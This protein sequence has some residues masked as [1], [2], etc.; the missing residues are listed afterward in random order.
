MKYAKSVT[1]TGS[2]SDSAVS[3]IYKVRSPVKLY[4]LHIL[5]YTTILSKSTCPKTVNFNIEQAIRADQLLF[6]QL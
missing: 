4:V 3:P 1:L 6:V 5:V 2:D